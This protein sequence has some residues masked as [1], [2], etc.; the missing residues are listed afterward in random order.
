MRKK[1][2]LLDRDGTLIVDKIYLNDPA[3][4]EYLPGVFDALRLLRDAGYVFAV[5][6]NQSGVPRGFVDVENLDE[7]HRIIRADFARQGVDILSFHSAPYMTDSNHPMRKPNTGMLDEAARFYGL[8][9]RQSWMIGDRMTDVEA[10][11]RAGTRTVLLGATEDPELSGYAAPTLRVADLLEAAQI[12][13][14][15]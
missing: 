12:I 7:I 6:T 8:D 15:L 2:I 11:R 5:A 14:R 10:G 13:S 1:A 3:Q 9:L 4:I